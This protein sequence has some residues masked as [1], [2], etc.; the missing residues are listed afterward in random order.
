MTQRLARRAE[1]RFIT[2]SSAAERL[3]AWF[4]QGVDRDELSRDRIENGHGAVLSCSGK[5]G[6]RRAW[7]GS[8]SLVAMVTR[9]LTRSGIRILHS[10]SRRPIP[11][12]SALKESADPPQHHRI[13]QM[14]VAAVWLT[15]P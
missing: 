5:G 10:R 3:A 9:L 14:M 2:T 11:A 12:P 8:G 15:A 7:I 13:S 6:T 1:D 4:D